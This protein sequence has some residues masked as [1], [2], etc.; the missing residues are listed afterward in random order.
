MAS[1]LPLAA[2]PIPPLT[3]PATGTGLVE[4]YIVDY[5][6]PEPTGM[7]IGVLDVDG[8]RFMARSGPDG[9]AIVQTMI[10]H[11]PLGARVTLTLDD[12]GHSVIH[13]LTPAHPA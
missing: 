13:S 9:A 3:A 8:S 11:D 2:R 1:I 6:R 4:T 5:S 7:V 12:K 10:D